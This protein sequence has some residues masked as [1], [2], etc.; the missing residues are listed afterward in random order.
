MQAQQ[1]W[2]QFERL[3]GN[4]LTLLPVASSTF[5]RAAMLA[6]DESA[7]LRAGD[8]LHLACAVE[9]KAQGIV[10]LDVAMSKTAQRLGIPSIPA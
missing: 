3:C 1:A 5:H 9:S 4:D 2:N 6:L 8:A 7:G 10:T